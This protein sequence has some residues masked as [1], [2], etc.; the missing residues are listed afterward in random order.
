ME[1]C[2][3]DI[4]T[5]VLVDFDG[6]LSRKDT[7]FAFLRFTHGHYGF[8]SRMA[9]LAPRL[10]MYSVG[11]GSAENAK[12]A[13][14]HAF[15][16]D[17]HRDALREQGMRFARRLAASDGMMHGSIVDLIRSHVQCGATVCIVSASPDVWVRPFAEQ[18]GSDAICTEL[19]YGVDERFTGR[20]AGPN[21]NG[22][23]KV[24][25]ICS[26]YDL[27]RFNRIIAFGN[28]VGDLPMLQLADEAYMVG[29]DGSKNRVQWPLASPP[30]NGTT[31]GK[32]I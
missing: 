25:A 30:S 10:G 26:C 9:I 21:I 8:L 11:V 6:T 32:R 15:Y 23:E 7:L 14:L 31:S 1:H 20:F 28:S 22:P 18:L 17:W 19:S 3:V 12:A 13:V 5:L 4:Q 27:A 24:R 29:R 16:K 2:C